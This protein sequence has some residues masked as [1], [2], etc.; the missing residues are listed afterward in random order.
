MFFKI[1]QQILSTHLTKIMGAIPS[2]ASHPILN[3]VL[4]KVANEQV[5]LTAYD[6]NLGIETKFKAQVLQEGNVAL[7]AKL[8][9]SLVTSLPDQ[10]LTLK[11]EENP[12]KDLGVTLSLTSASYQLKGHKIDEFPLFPQLENAQK[13]T[14]DTTSFS[15]GLQTVLSAIATDETKQCLTGIRLTLAQTFLE[16]ASTDGHRL[17]LIKAKLPRESQG[18]NSAIGI[19]IPGVAMKE[20]GKLIGKPTI[21][22][23][24]DLNFQFDEN[25]IIINLPESTLVC[26]VL[27]GEYP[28]YQVLI[29]HSFQV[30]A[31]VTKDALI[32]AISRLSLL[33]SQNPAIRL[34]LD[35]DNQQINLFNQDSIVG[36]GVESLPALVNG[37][38]KIAF[39]PKYLLQG[40]KAIPT[41]E[42]KFL[43][44]DGKTPALCQGVNST[45]DDCFVLLMP[46]FVKGFSD[47][48]VTVI[49][50]LNQSEIM[51]I[52]ES[53]TTNN[54]EETISEP[55]IIVDTLDDNLVTEPEKLTNNQMESIPENSPEI[56]GK[57]SNRRPSKKSK[58]SSWIEDPELADLPM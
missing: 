28:Q 56:K 58:Y 40:V 27:A 49:S 6:L 47:E 43:I 20:L 12:E 51:E 57:K 53:V 44:N 38:A 18:Q 16:M 32:K 4:I 24:C 37:N 14:I 11:L 46:C 9:H 55:E 30:S 17:A 31:N 41:S 21:E 25:Q 26:R 42:I 39:N 7:P 10:E 23:D 34:T 3:N 1:S 5:T 35:Y 8:F 13:L 2:K 33:D 48:E 54:V 19:T 36:N 52:E 22:N 50:N 45:L 29:P 15:Q